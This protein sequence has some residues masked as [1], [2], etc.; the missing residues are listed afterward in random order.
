MPDKPPAD[1]T[2]ID[3]LSDFL[4]S[5]SGVEA[6]RL[7]TT[8]RSVQVA[9]LGQVDLAALQTQVSELLKSLDERL[10][11]APAKTDDLEGL[12]L[13]RRE[14]EVLLQKPTCPTAPRFWKWRD[15]EWPEAEEI[16]KQSDEEWRVMAVQATICGLMQVAAYVAGNAFGAPEWVRHSLLG[17]ALVSGGWDAAKDAWENLKERRLD[18]HFLMLAVATG[19]VAIGAWE[20]GALLL[21]LFSTSGALEHFVLH[22]THR[23]INALMKVV[24]KM[25]RV[26][27]PDGSVQE[28]AVSLLRVGDVVQVRPAELFPVDATVVSGETAADE[29]TLTGEALPIDKTKGAVVYGGTLNLW[30]LVQAHVDRP[31][32]QSAL[33][34]IITMIQTAQ[35]MRAPSQRFTDRFGTTYT[36]LTLSVVLVMFLVWW[37]ALGIVPFESSDG[38]RSAFYRAMTLLV[39]MSPCA[40]V[41][42][43]PSAILAAIAWGARR[44]ILFRGGA[45]IEKLAEV[46]LV[47][48]DKTGTLTEGNLRVALVESFPPGREKEVLR[49]A[50]TLDTNSNHPIALAITRHAKEQGI[51]PGELIEFQSIPGQGLRGRTADGVTYVG[52]R[53]LMDQ[54]DFAQWLKDVPDAPLG[55]SEV[56]VLNA[57]TMGRVLL[58]DEIRSGSKAVLAQ[59]AAEHVITVMLTGDRRAA[60][61][62]IAQELGVTD[63]RAGL[64]PEDKVAAIKEFT[65]KGHKVAMVGDG[66]NDAP[67]LAA[68][69]VSVAMGA[70]GSDAALEQ[71]DVVLMQDKIEKLLSARHISQTARRIIRQNLAISLGSVIIMAVASLFGIVPLTLGVLTH[72]GS[73]VLVCLNSLRLLFVKEAILITKPAD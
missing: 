18:V 17:V 12:Q 46:D 73:T 67:S 66:V 40:L 58:K 59:L 56:W 49:L 69:Y 51:E 22:R 50:V 61:T 39:V 68:A 60:A 11:A 62:Q 38:T 24:P 2:W 47:A 55:F 3:A 6:I 57:G 23:E 7:N 42:S 72:E 71:A 32:T 44:G 26:I 21:F 8:D 19:A 5:Q 35:H 37:L 33:A 27:L 36:L 13:T 14:G 53:E 29:S 48:M 54:G 4:A 45:A 9:T 64:H 31:A 52:R 41:L 25:A 16:E 30:G 10:L 28:R 20:E 43:I 1:I 34:K 70:R 15:F 65:D 63:V